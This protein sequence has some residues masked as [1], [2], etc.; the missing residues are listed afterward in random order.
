MGFWILLLER[1][2]RNRKNERKSLSIR[3]WEAE[4]I[5]LGLLKWEKWDGGKADIPQPK[6]LYVF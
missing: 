6:T 4:R 1:G 5:L 2:R 3:E